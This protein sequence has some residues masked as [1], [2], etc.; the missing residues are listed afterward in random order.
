MRTGSWLAVS[1][2][3][4]ILGCSEDKKSPTVRDDDAVDLDRDG[5]AQVELPTDGGAEAS[6]TQPDAGKV[7]DGV[8]ACTVK[9]VFGTTVPGNDKVDLLFVIDNSSSMKEEQENLATQ[10]PKLIH[11]LST[12][13]LEDAT[14]RVVRKFSPVRSLHLGV[15]SSDLGVNGLSADIQSIVRCPGMGDD[16]LLLNAP[17]PFDP[18]CVD[19]SSA[20]KYLEFQAGADDVT[21]LG[22]DF[23]CIARLGTDGCGFEQQLEAM[24]KALAPSRDNTFTAGTVGHGDLENAGF[25]RTDSVLAVIHVSDE[26]DCSI[27]DSSRHLFAPGTGDERN[28]LNVRC[29][30][31][32]E[33]QHPVRRYVR[34]LKSLRP[35]HPEQVIFAAIVGIAPAAEAQVVGNMQDFD[36]ILARADMQHAEQINPDGLVFPQHSCQSSHGVAFAPRR[37]V[38]VAKGFG[39]NGLVRSI[40]QEDFSGALSGLI[41]K[42][43]DRLNSEEGTCALDAECQV[44][45]RCAQPGSQYAGRCVSRECVEVF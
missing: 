1:A 8:M 38:E 10:L 20:N 32:P 7:R 29:T 42:I 16:G 45:F 9:P 4:A 5:G 24:W 21:S 33:L 25:L 34:G 17:D 43:A 13:L 40:C 6:A 23:A 41:D 44:G 18:T 37:F 2:L 39:R 35:N 27:P 22:R 36:G 19:G 30:R 11:V 14:G 26:E 3:L 12:G 31:N 15:T 28:D